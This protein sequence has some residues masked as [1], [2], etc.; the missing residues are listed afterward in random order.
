MNSR[1]REWSHH[2]VGPEKF[3]LLEIEYEALRT[4][5][6][7]NGV[8][9]ID[10]AVW[11]I[12]R[13]VLFERGLLDELHDEHGAALVITEAGRELLVQVGAFRTE[14]RRGPFGLRGLFRPAPW[15]LI[16]YATL[17]ALVAIVAAVAIVVWA[18]LQ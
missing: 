7:G 16:D 18:R 11:D 6:E 15:S 9:A 13:P 8:E 12:A 1:E 10:P 17:A 2:T 4:L 3:G 5:E 14:V